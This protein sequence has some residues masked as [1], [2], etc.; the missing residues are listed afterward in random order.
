M[1]N[2]SNATTSATAPHTTTR[3]Q[4]GFGS[5]A[6]ISGV[7]GETGA[8]LEVAADGPCDAG[9]KIAVGAGRSGGI[10]A[11][12]SSAGNET[13]DGMVAPRATPT[14]DVSGVT[15]RPAKRTSAAV[16]SAAVA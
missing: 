7:S 1:K 5:V 13:G 6:G 8:S 16:K 2:P 11:G 15:D 10:G 14:C 4:P 3:G 12:T 9:F